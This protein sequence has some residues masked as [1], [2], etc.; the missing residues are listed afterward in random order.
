[1]IKKKKRKNQ[2]TNLYAIYPYFFDK[3][4][5]LT[6][7]VCISCDANIIASHCKYAP[8]SGIFDL[9]PYIDWPNPSQNLFSGAINRD[10]NIQLQLSSIK[11]YNT[12]QYVF[13]FIFPL[14][15]VV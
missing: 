3:N 9:L 8:S 13:I 7:K 10:K 12:Y 2:S 11:P 1:M 6:L 15:S 5:T 4:S 14:L